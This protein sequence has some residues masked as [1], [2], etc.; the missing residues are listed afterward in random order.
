MKSDL[1][2]KIAEKIHS[3]FS[4]GAHLTSCVPLAGDASSR[5]YHRAML[6]GPSAPGSIVVMELCDDTIPLSSEELAIF[7]EPPKEL[8][9]INL[10]RF[11]NNVGVRIPALYRYWPEEGILFLED[12][13]DLSL[14]EWVQ[15]L[16]PADAAKWYEKAINQLLKIQLQ[17]SRARNDACIAFEQR[18]DFRLYMWEFEHFIDYGIEKGKKGTMETKA[19]DILM[20]QF[21]LISR[22]L[23]RQPLY[24]N[25]RDYHSWNL[26]VHNG[27][28]VVIDFQD[29]LLAPSQYDL[30]SLLNDRVTDSVI[31][32]ETEM[33][34]LNYYQKEWEKLGGG[35]FDGDAFFENY[36]LSAFQRDLKVIGRFHYLDLIKG[37]PGYKKYIP[38]TVRRAG[39]NLRRLPRL[40]N[41]IS[42]LAP[43][44][45]EI[46]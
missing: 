33:H 44:F 26:M 32:P 14:W 35:R 34:L 28:L 4:R 43:Y 42:L 23:D 38:A 39:R 25:H 19:K 37:K 18:F 12:L 27:E 7:K 5:R 46:R 13:G 16:S 24:L 15:T 17:G 20:E 30:A 6:S 3:S 40:K 2:N 11:L 9:F 41:L 31:L 1:E 22:H 45:E 36:V 8:P 29:A 10:H 21:A